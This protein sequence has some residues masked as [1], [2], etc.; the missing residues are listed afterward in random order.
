MYSCLRLFHCNLIS[1]GWAISKSPELIRTVPKKMQLWTRVFNKTV[2]KAA[3]NFVGQIPF[4]PCLQPAGL[5]RQRVRESATAANAHW[6]L[7][8]K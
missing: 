8:D 2:E 5:Q 1:R 7:G 6:W 3:G 4:R